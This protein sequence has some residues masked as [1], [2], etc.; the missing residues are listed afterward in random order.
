[1]FF[2]MANSA[3]STRTGAKYTMWSKVAATFSAEPTRP[4]LE[5]CGATAAA[6]RRCVS[7]A[8][9]VAAALSPATSG[10]PRS[11]DRKQWK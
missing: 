6:M 3:L 4:S 2:I 8:A 5:K 10:S 9:S 11:S 1:M 7:S